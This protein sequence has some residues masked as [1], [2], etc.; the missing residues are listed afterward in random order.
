MKVAVLFSGGKD[1]TYSIYKA[2]ME[3][4]QVECVVTIFPQSQESQLLHFPNIQFTKLQSESMNIPQISTE[5]DSTNPNAEESTLEQ[6]I[7]NAKENYGIEG[8]VHGGILSEFQKKR[9]EKI[10]NNLGISLISPLWKKNQKEY[11]ENLLKSKFQFIIISVTSGGLDESWLGKEIT[12]EDLI[13]LQ[14][15]SQKNG[16]NLSFEGGE[17]ETFVTNCPLFTSPIKIEK[18]KTSWDGYRGRFEILE[19]K[20]DNNA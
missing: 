4:H 11:M 14:N 12:T 8:I 2:K 19:A 15:L 1:S 7:I 20:L 5:V 6:I 10:S 17:A 3:G 9:F 16:F 18:S 13:T